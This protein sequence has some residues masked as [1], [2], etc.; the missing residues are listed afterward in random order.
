LQEF[1]MSFISSIG[2][3]ARSALPLLSSPLASRLEQVAL[4]PQPLP[5]KAS[6][7]GALASEVLDDWCGTVPKRFPPVPPQPLGGGLLDTANVNAVVDAFR[8]RF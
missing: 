5:P 4:N 3:A 6:F 7:G 1:T 8:A 2:A